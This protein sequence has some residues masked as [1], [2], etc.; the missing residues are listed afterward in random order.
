[1]NNDEIILMI[2]DIMDS[3][4]GDWYRFYWE[5]EIDENYFWVGIYKKSSTAYK[6]SPTSINY[7]TDIY[8]LKHIYFQ[9]VNDQLE[10]SPDLDGWE[11]INHYD[12]D[13]DAKVLRMFLEIP[14]GESRPTKSI[15]C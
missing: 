10:I 9:Y 4:L 1:M 2:E 11:E 12:I 15:R 3:A 8:F 14:K 6:K 13:A 7:E 5:I